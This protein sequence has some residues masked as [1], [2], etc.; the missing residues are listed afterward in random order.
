MIVDP[1]TGKVIFD[2]NNP[3]F[4]LNDDNFETLSVSEIETNRVASPIG[5][6]LLIQSDAGLSLV[7]TEGIAIESKSVTLEAA[8]NITIDSSS[9]LMSGSIAIDPLALPLGGGGYPG[10]K[11]H[12]KICICHPSGK[13]FV[14]PATTSIGRNYCNANFHRGE[15]HPCDEDD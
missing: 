7:G 5:K 14:I 3:V 13:L 9:I 2:A 12:F 15:G 10:E 4:N 6:D 11:P 1:D 8:E